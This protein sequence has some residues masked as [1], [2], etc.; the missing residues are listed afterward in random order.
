MTRQG[1]DQQTLREEAEISLKETAAVVESHW[2]V[3]AS[4][5]HLGQLRFEALETSSA[6]PGSKLCEGCEEA[7]G[8]AAAEPEPRVL[9]ISS[10]PVLATSRSTPMPATKVRGSSLKIILAHAVR[11]NHRDSR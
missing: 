9:V 8:F 1:N 11:M 5:L 3:I 6:D 7:A 10:P 4:I 2:R